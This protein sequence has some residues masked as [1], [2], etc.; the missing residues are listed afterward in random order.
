L[1]I[2]RGAGVFSA[3]LA[4]AACAIAHVTQ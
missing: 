2:S 4:L 3:D 1:A